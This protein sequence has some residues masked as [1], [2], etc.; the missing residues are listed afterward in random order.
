MDLKRS[1]QSA[2]E[3]LKLEISLSREKAVFSVNKE[4]ILLYWKKDPRNA[5]E[6]R[7]GN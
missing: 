2:I 7:V 4:L 6:R 5:G 3:D 1:Y